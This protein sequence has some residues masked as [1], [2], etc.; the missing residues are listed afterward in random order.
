ML[1]NAAGGAS[2]RA[3]A[4]LRASVKTRSLSAV[5]FIVYALAL[6]LGLGL[7]SAYWVL[8]GDP[9]F[10]RL[11]LG[12]WSAWPKLGSPQ[13][14]PY[15]RAINARRSA[16]P[17]AIGEGLALHATA[18]SAGR[19]LDAACTYRIGAVTPAARI[20]TLALYDE[21]GRLPQTE[22][23][24]PGFTSAELLRDRDGGFAIMLSRSLQPGNWIQIP[25]GGRFSLVL[26][27]YDTP[28]ATGTGLDA[29][30]LPVIERLECGA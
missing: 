23:G 2:M 3:S 24:R 9:P 18:D 11:R 16:I 8:E 21:A 22:L 13:A 27:L 7:G 12:A 6:A 20:W 1:T 29:A 4:I 5:L 25:A 14:D 30:A 19:P 26:R 17:L 28:G 15:M 10:G